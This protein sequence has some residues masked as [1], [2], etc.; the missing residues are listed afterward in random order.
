MIKLRLLRLLLVSVVFGVVGYAAASVKAQT[1]EPIEQEV[2][3]F[4]DK[5]IVQ[6]T[7]KNTFES[8]QV[9][10]ISVYDE[11]KQP[12]KGAILS[13]K[14]VILERLKSRVVTAMIP[15]DGKTMRV[16]YICHAIA[17]QKSES[18]PQDQNEACGKYTARRLS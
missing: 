6:V 1:I 8:T 2:T 9:S 10:E 14:Q 4:S 17:P 5:F 13:H 3:G 16:V 15:F 7:I 12:L 18:M 11:N